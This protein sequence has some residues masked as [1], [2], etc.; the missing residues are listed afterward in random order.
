M[1]VRTNKPSPRR[2]VL[3]YTLSALLLAGAV[4]ACA[5]YVPAVKYWS[6]FRHYHWV[7]ASWYAAD[8]RA[9]DPDVRSQAATFLHGRCGEPEVSRWFVAPLRDPDP[10]VRR[11][12]LSALVCARLAA[13]R[14]VLSDADLVEALLRAAGQ[15]AD[16]DVRRLASGELKLLRPALESPGLRA[17][18]DGFLAPVR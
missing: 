14:C 1:R 13:G 17:R 10:R 16:G 4:V 15:D 3:V 8:L 7:P 11:N 18:V 5:R 9:E 6:Q 12:A 2:R